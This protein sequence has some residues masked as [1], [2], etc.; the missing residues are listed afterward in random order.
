SPNPSRRR[1]G[2]TPPLATVLY[3]LHFTSLQ[4]TSLPS[5]SFFTFF[6]SSLSSLATGYCLPPTPGGTPAYS[7]LA[8]ESKRSFKRFGGGIFSDEIGTVKVA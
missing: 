3:S 1:E 5:L 2:D 8:G 4:F 7:P 6:L